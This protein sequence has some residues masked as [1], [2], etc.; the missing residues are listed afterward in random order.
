M[1]LKKYIRKELSK[2]RFA[3]GD[4][5]KISIA[6][7]R[8]EDYFP[9][10]FYAVCLI[11]ADFEMAWASRYTKGSADPLGKAI[12]DG[13]RTRI[14]VPKVLS[15]CDT[16]NIPITWATVGHLF[17]EACVP[18]NGKKHPDL[19]RLPHFENEYWRFESGDWFDFDPCTD[20][21]R[22]PAWYAPDLIQDILS[23]KVKHEIGCHTFSHIDCRDELES[24]IV[25]EAEIQKC[26]DLAKHESITLKSFVHPGHTIGNL[27]TLVSKGFTSYRTDYLDSLS[28]PIH[29]ENG[30]WEYLNSA[31]L[32]WREGWTPRYHIKRYK[33]VIDRAIR[34]KRLCVLWFHPSF[35]ES[36]VEFVLPE[37]LEYLDAKRGKIAC[38][39]HC[40]Y[41]EFL[42]KKLPILERDVDNEL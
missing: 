15:L 40:D 21:I 37:V 39:T 10:P 14:N 32:D 12:Q 27:D 7:G 17:L 9:K 1:N 36:F 23:R 8:A 35:P 20:Y 2:I 25:F 3:I 33:A 38:M 6:S 26:I 5:P 16:Y 24:K 28:L 34:H 30:I 19:P 41:T 29:H 31:C 13:L 11:S 4:V 22:D 18:V 42:N